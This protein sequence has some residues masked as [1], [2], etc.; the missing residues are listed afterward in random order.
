M[1]VMS[2]KC[3]W[4]GMLTVTARCVKRRE[5]KR[6]RVRGITSYISQHYNNVRDEDPR[7]TM[8]PFRAAG[9]GAETGM[10]NSAELFM[11]G[12]IIEV[13]KL[14]TQA[15]PPTFIIAGRDSVGGDITVITSD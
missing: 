15:D 8:C 2:T 12:G 6:G 14:I 3:H 11:M 4:A 13:N 10:T 9:T 1:V 7:R 5:Q